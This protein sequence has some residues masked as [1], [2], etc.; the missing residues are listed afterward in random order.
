MG[1]LL[2]PSFANIFMCA[3]EQSFLSNCHLHCK[4][5]LYR[6]YVD[7]T[8]C[9]FKNKS[10]AESFLQYFNQQRPNISFTYELEAKN[11]LQFLDVL[12]IHAGNVFSFNLYRKKTFTGLHT[13]FDSLSPIHYN[14]NLITVLIYCAYH[15]CSSF[16][17][18]HEQVVSIKRFLRYNH[19]PLYL[20][21]RV[22]KKFLDK[23]YSNKVIPFNVPRLPV[24][25]FLPYLGSRRAHLE[26]KL[27]IV[28][29]KHL[30]LN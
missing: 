1:S 11:L 2:G 15:I 16:F 27:K 24:P 3:L 9:I 22:I 26:K 19:F 25:I 7:D 4:P 30:P 13:N 23:Q 28:F 12:I 18:F 17:S 10:Q 20:I 6:R 8:L 21:N 5:L 14:V 29:G